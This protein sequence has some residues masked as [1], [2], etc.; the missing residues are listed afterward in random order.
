MQVVGPLY[1]IPPGYAE[2]LQASLFLSARPLSRPWSSALSCISD[3]HLSKIINLLDQQGRG[4]LTHLL[5]NT[6]LSLARADRQET[7]HCA[8]VSFERHAAN[9]F[10]RYVHGALNFSIKR[11]GL[12]YGS[13]GEGGHVRVDAIYEPPQVALPAHSACTA[14]ACSLCLSPGWGVPICWTLPFQRSCPHLLYML[15][16]QITK[17]TCGTWVWPSAPSALQHEG[18]ASELQHVRAT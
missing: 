13:M 5:C 3:P 18:L 8:S 16:R 10:Q 11:G 9:A 1:H 6:I 12:L 14:T 15:L 4:S 7:P 17:P 2:P